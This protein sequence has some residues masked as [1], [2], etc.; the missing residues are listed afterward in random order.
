ML[1]GGAGVS[2]GVR[3]RNITSVRVSISLSWLGAPGSSKLTFVIRKKAAIRA[4][5]S[6]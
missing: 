4:I 5:T 2:I 1:E 3:V 6:L